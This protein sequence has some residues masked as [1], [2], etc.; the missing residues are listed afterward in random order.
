MTVIPFDPTR[1]PRRA[2]AEA[3]ALERAEARIAMLERT[4]LG[5]LRENARNWARAEHAEARL[6]ELERADG[7]RL[8]RLTKAPPEASRQGA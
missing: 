1:R 5:T 8:H 3:S 4:L 6:A 2:P 7:P